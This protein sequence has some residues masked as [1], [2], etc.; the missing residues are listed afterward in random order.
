MTNRRLV[1][2][3]VSVASLGALGLGVLA[4]AGPA[5]AQYGATARYE[6]TLTG[7]NEAP[8]PGDPDGSGVAAVKVKQGKQQVCV[9]I[10]KVKNLALPATAAHIHEAPA[11]VAGPIRV[12][13]VPPKSK[14][15]DRVGKSKTCASVT[16]PLLAN[17]LGY[18]AS[19]YVNVHTTQ[20]PSGAIRGQLG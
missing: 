11:G 7:A 4:L 10:K 13:L 16:G 12:T 18:P 1:A 5:G 8:G 14:K 17:L 3:A 15:P 9:I 19:F 20:F 2:S 6:T